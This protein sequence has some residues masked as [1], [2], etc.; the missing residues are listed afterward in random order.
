[1][2][3]AWQVNRLTARRSVT[4][5]VNEGLLQ[6][7]PGVGTFV[8][9]RKS[10]R[11]IST[12]VSFWEATRTLGMKPSARLIG[13]ETTS[14][15]SEIA[16]ALELE[17]GDPVCCIR[18]LRLADD[19]IM[20]YHIA[21]IPARLFP[22]LM[23]KDLGNLSLYALYRAYGYAP[24]SGEQRIRAQAAHKEFSKLLGIAFGAP[25]LSL[26]R[27]TR[28]SNGRPIEFLIAYY[29]SDR[30]VIHMPLYPPGKISQAPPRKRKGWGVE[31]NLAF[32]RD[33]PLSSSEPKLRRKIP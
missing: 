13:K 14:A 28:A 11:E 10:L 31:P 27:V 3:N 32:E 25:V 18:R 12:L 7:R 30:H 8:I 26:H 23:E 29:R 22:G 6:R 21:T 4:D 9:R 16:E 1:L 15:S 5:L 17:R 24:A 2:A 33:N 20:A 19:E